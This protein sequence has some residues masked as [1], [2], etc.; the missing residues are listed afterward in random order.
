MT[1]KIFLYRLT[2]QV[3]DAE[4][5]F[6]KVRETNSILAMNKAFLIAKE[7]EEFKTGNRTLHLMDTYSEQEWEDLKVTH[8]QMTGKRLLNED[9]PNLN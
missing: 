6:I 9:L 1:P 5:Y 8:F 2:M 4:E 3:G 7:M